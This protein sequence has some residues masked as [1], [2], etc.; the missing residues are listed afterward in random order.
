MTTF[1][2]PFDAS[3]ITTTVHKTHEQIPITGSILTGT[4]D[5][6]NIKYFTHDMFESV[7]DYPYLSSSANHIL[8]LTYGLSSTSNLSASSPTEIANP[9]QSSKINVYNNF[10]KLLVGTDATGS[11]RNFTTDGTY[12]GTPMKECLFMPFARL[13]TKDEIQKGT[14]SLQFSTGGVCTTTSPT[15]VITLQDTNA[16]VDY[17]TNSPAG[18]WSILYQTTSDEDTAIGH[19]YYQAGIAVLSCSMFNAEANDAANY[20]GTGT[21]TAAR[22]N[23]DNINEMLTGS[24]ISGGCDAVR[25]RMYN[26]SYNNTTAIQSTVYFCR[27]NHAEFNFSSNVTYLS[28]AFGSSQIRC[29]SDPSAQSKT[30]I[31]SIGLYN[32]NSELMGIAKLSRPILKSTGIEQIFKVLFSF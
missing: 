13:L 29:K 20:L 27:A 10:A 23:F 15:D 21:A 12:T 18:E 28:G 25:N 14:V 8:D 7:Y 5:D 4:Y 3:D 1:F 30:Y 24:S 19:I 22:P 11:I 26:I 31:T 32:S 9:Q 2:K 17:K 16:T 6:A